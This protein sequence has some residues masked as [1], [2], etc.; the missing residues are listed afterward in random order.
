MSNEYVPIYINTDKS[1][2]IMD[3]DTNTV[4]YYKTTNK[5]DTVSLSSIVNYN[6]DGLLYIDRLSNNIRDHIMLIF[7]K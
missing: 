2:T 4:G 6:N 5:I 3:D 1:I 7:S